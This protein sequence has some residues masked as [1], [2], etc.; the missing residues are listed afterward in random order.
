MAAFDDLDAELRDLVNYGPFNPDS[1]FAVRDMQRHLGRA[2]AAAHVRAQIA[3]LAE[4]WAGTTGH[5]WKPEKGSPIAGTL[6]P[7]E[8]KVAA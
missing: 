1:V 5:C 3:R 6:A 8:R 2:S 7:A 4:T